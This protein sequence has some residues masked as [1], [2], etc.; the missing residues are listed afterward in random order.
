M[1]VKKINSKTVVVHLLENIDLKESQTLTQLLEIL[2]A[3]GAQVVRL[4][5][6]ITKYMRKS[7]L[8]PLIAYHEK[9]KKRGGGLTFVNVRGKNVR[10]LFD[11]LEFCRIIS[12]EEAT[13]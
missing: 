3:E 8:A 11:M 10:H 2:Y 13:T 12:I 9:L 6:A 7:C 5:F 4:D 1:E